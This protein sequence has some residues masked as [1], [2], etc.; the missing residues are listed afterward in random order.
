MTTCP[1]RWCIGAMSLLLPLLTSAQTPAIAPQPETVDGATAYA[2]KTVGET[3]LRLHVFKADGAKAGIPTPAIIFFF[4]GGFTQGSVTQFAPQAK[5]F[6]Q[7]GMVAVVAD[8]RV[9]GRHG[10]SP[11]EAMTDAKSAV[12]W[13]RA[14]SGELGVDP[15]RI[16][17]AGGSSGGHIAASAAVFDTFERSR[18]GQEGEFT[19]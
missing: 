5:H 2:Y 9:F 17:A 15:K 11:F 10:T 7:R 16:A 8:Y 6:A 19:S 18:R 14:H 3:K 12:R 13:V 4:G 1:E